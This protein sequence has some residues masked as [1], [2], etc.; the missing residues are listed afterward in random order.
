M[1]PFL[2]NLM[3]VVVYFQ[4]FVFHMSKAFFS[5]KPGRSLALSTCHLAS[6]ISKKRKFL[7]ERHAKCKEIAFHAL[8]KIMH[9]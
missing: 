2:I 9:D 5:M 3:H 4:L 6:Y 1:F 8:M 7:F